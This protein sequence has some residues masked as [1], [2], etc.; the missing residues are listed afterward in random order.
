MDELFRQ[1]L[2]IARGMWRRRWVGV[3]VAWAV[4]LVGAILVARMPERFEA[5]ARIYVDTQTVLKPLMQGLAVQPDINQQVAMVA[6][7]LITRPNVEKL[8]RATDLDHTVR[9]PQ[10]RDQLVDR[11]MREIQL[12]G[13]GREN[14]FNV[15]YR[16]TRPERA[17][18]L[19]QTLVSLFVES[20]LGNK[21]RDTEDAR[22]F[23]EEEIRTQE[24]RLEE[25]ESRLKE[26]KVRNLAIAETGGKD[27]FARLNAATEELAKARLEL[28]A[29]EQSRDALKRGLGDEEPVLLP[30]PG[31]TTVIAVPELDA[32]IDALRR[33]LDEQLR[34][35][36]EEHP[37]V[38][39]TRRLIAQLE[40]QRRVEI[41]ARR[42]AAIAKPGPAT[43]PVFQRIKIALAEAD[44]TV[45]SLRGR[46]G[47][48][49]GRVDQ[50]RAAAGR[51]PQVEAEM[52]QLNR[53]Y[54]IVKR[55]Y[56]ALVSRREQ[57]MTSRNIDEMGHLAEFRVIEPPR[58]APRPVFP[59]R[60]SLVPFVLLAA[61]GA[62]VVAA[63]VA[64][65]LFPTIDTVRALRTV[66]QRPV[67]GSVS[68]IVSEGLARRLRWLNVAF[69]GSLVMLVIV[70]GAWTAWLAV[71]STARIS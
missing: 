64:S 59:N 53:D 35:F 52:A 57:L 56:E 31:V 54:E 36:T 42:R 68:M 43:N 16:D 20:G 11:L 47:E 33:Q 32:R 4:A 62:G 30:D 12:V 58:V 7:T 48:L 15:S 40:E 70:Y 39:T 13:G 25:A 29:A 45:A 1:L 24:K 38:A 2:I 8:I 9:S 63:F 18:L 26:F 28:R 41:D 71:T 27:Y 65:Q 19:V 55:Q 5:T 60:L 21:R 50:L 23:I 37:D 49:Q 66:I 17:K 67:L 61:L 10:E 14:L 46:V 34:R 22:R 69:A 44:A 51:I 3:A 6:R